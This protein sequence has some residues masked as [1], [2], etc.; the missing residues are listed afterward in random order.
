MTAAATVQ[1]VSRDVSY[2]FAEALLPLVTPSEGRFGLQKLD[3]SLAGR[4]ENYSD[5]GTTSNPK[6]GIRYVPLEGFTLRGTWGKSFKAPT[7]YQLFSEHNLDYFNVQLLGS[8]RSGNALFDYGGNPDLKPERAKSWTAGIDWSPPSI[9]SLDVSVT[10]FDIDYTNRIT[11][12]ISSPGTALSN[13]IFAPFVI[14]N[15]TPS[16]LATLLASTPIFLNFSGV[17]YSPAQTIDVLEDRYTNATAQQIDGVDLSAK[18]SFAIARGDIAFFVNATWLRLTQQTI[19]TVPAVTLTGTLFQPPKARVRSGLTWTYDGFTVTGIVNYISDETDTNV[20]PSAPVAS[21]TTLD[22]NF[23]YRV[24]AGLGVLSG[25]EASLAVTNAFDREPPYAK[26]AA[27]QA[28]G[29]YFDSTNTSAIG[30]FV[31]LTLR[32]RF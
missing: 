20:T 26:G 32:K 8:S 16:Q 15:P 5:F 19:S 17:A 9:P 2:A 28:Q 12:P 25:L 31:A 7:F 24:R 18:K 27:L 4:I 23:A 11:Y 14:S 3:L 10:Y 30:R 21:W 6:L 22:L 1:S 13:S 29:V